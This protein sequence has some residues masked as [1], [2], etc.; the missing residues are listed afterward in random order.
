MDFFKKHGRTLLAIFSG[1]LVFASLF[2]WMLSFADKRER[3]AVVVAV[4]DLEV[5]HI[6]AAE[7]IVLAQRARQ[8]V[9]RTGFVNTQPLL[10][11]A[12]AVAVSKNDMVTT[13]HIIQGINE[14]SQSFLL[15]DGA[16]GFSL[17]SVWLAAP[18]TKLV[19]NDRITLLASAANSVEAGGTAILGEHIPVLGVER[20]KDTL[21]V[22]MLLGI[23]MSEAARITQAH[24]NHLAMILIL[25]PAFAA[26]AQTATSSAP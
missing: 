25:E 1:V 18:P 23:T 26:P 9:P 6:I 8:D 22:W 21:P 7:D 11:T 5:S 13:N 20:G 17:P 14:G 4:R 10:G 3:I 12:L 15:K 19:I 16:F 24:A 2:Y